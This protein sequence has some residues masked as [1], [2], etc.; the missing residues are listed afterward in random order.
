MKVVVLD[1]DGVRPAMAEAIKAKSGALYYA[2]RHGENGRGRWEVRFP[3]AAREFPVPTEPVIGTLV[4]DIV[5]W[6]HCPIC[7][8]RFW[9]STQ[10]LVGQKCPTCREFGALNYKFLDLKEVDL[11]LVD[12]KKIDPRGN[13]QYLLARG[14]DDG[15]YLVLW[16]L[17][18]GFRGGADYTVSSNAKIIAEGEEAQ[19]D[20]GHMGGAMCPV[21]LVTGPCRLQWHRTG[22]LYGRPADWTA[23]FDGSTWTVGSSCECALEEAALNY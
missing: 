9:D 13:G 2:V 15:N 8:K 7:K 21:V 23:E 12:L 18:P 22:R 4:E 1:R 10:N 5:D 6:A 16:S 11:K 19:G 17:D 3:L 20:A 14:E